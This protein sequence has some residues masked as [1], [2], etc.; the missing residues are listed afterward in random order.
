VTIVKPYPYQTAKEFVA[1]DVAARAA[2][3]RYRQRISLFISRAG[4]N[5]AIDAFRTQIVPHIP[6]ERFVI[7]PATL[8]DTD[9]GHVDRG[10]KVAL[11]NEVGHPVGN[12]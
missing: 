2:Y 7:Q 9:T 1:A 4:A 10:F 6:R 8:R 5:R 12:L 11:L 3:Q